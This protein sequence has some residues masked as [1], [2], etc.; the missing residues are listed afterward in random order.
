MKTRN[1]VLAAL[2]IGAM[3][4]RA[5]I[6]RADDGPPIQIT[7]LASTGQSPHAA[8]S[9]V[10][11]WFQSKVDAWL[12]KNPNVRLEISYQ[13]N[14]INGA[15][16]H[17]Q[18]QLD[19]GRAPDFASLDS[20]FLSRFYAKLQPLDTYYPASDIKDFVSFANAGMHDA[21]GTLKA[22]WVNTDVRALFYRKDLVKT[23]PKTW[24]DLLALAPGLE[25]Q[26]ITPYVF[27]GGRGEASVM[28]HL[29]MFWAMGGKLVDD[30][31]NAA[32]GEGANRDDWIKILTFM[33][34]SVDSGASPQRVASYG[35]EADMNP[36]LVR[37]NVAMFLG[38][39][40][41]PGQLHGLGD[42][43][44]WGVAA[45]PMPDAATAASTAAGGWTFG[46]FTAD[47]VKQK[48]I[49]ELINQMAASPEG[50]SGLVQALG[51]LPTRVS[52]AAMDTPY[53]KTD[54]N[55]VFDAMLSDSHARPGAAIYPTISTELQV[56]IANVITGQQ[57]PAEA[58]D[59]A[60]KRVQLQAGK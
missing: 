3:V 35:S 52:V 23:P 27:P 25:K 56:A 1:I 60:F 49:V 33:K 39:S 9:P 48:L 7:W 12:K 36:E 17:L 41:Q 21:D 40:W 59:A 29:G 53:F 34:A 14:D 47:P 31:G 42:K 50:M 28:E 32:F 2:L 5:H 51:N 8:E 22:L 20:F 38:G 46:L 30:K 24:D 26:K 10:K 19:A 44:E 4:S 16:T 15:M 13:T 18:Q 43:H 11:Q 6:V 45:I 58:I 57:K 37:G 54:D 55:K